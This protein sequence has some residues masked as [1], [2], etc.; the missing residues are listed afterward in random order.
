VFESSA[1]ASRF[2]ELNEAMASS[3]S[4]CRGFSAFHCYAGLVDGHFATRVLALVIFPEA[5]DVNL[6]PVLTAQAPIWRS[7]RTLALTSCVSGTT[8]TQ[9]RSGS[10]GPE[11]PYPREYR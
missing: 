6:R 5:P 4:L 11:P 7:R 9:H 10:F 3:I 1:I 2:P 8:A